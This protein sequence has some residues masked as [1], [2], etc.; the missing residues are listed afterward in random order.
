[1]PR[2]RANLG[3]KVGRFLGDSVVRGTHSNE[4][5]AVSLSNSGIVASLANLQ[6][7]G[8]SALDTLDKEVK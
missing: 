7:Q 1:V 2:G 5:L 3:D 4:G 8:H 6:E